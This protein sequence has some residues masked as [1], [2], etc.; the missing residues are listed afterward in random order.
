MRS[1]IDSFLGGPAAAPYLISGTPE[2]T[3]ITLADPARGVIVGVPVEAGAMVSFNHVRTYVWPAQPPSAE[4][5]LIWNIC[6]EVRCETAVSGER[7]AIVST[8]QMSLGTQ[9]AQKDFYYPGAHYDG[10]E[11]YFKL[12]EISRSGFFAQCGVDIEAICKKFRCRAALYCS[13]TPKP[14]LD[15]ARRLWAQSEEDDAGAVR[16]LA[17][18]MLRRL[19]AQPYAPEGVEW[20]TRSQIAIA[21][22]GERLLCQDLAQ[23]V[24]LREAAARFG[25]SESSFAH[26]FCGVFGKSPADY[27]REKRMEQA[28]RLLASTDMSVAGVAAQVGYENQSKFAAVFRSKFGTAPLEYRR[29]ARLEELNKSK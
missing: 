9:Q 19:A 2:R 14:V 3:T 7:S 16:L 20:F 24:T 6:F 4:E 12:G 27:V 10:V 29:A 26:Y 18:I 15:I 1:N 28:C 5:T 21:R 8:G 11:L 17:A 25:V 22:D 23:R 13:R